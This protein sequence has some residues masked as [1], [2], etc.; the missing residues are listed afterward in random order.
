[1]AA[2]PSRN[3]SEL[4][5]ALVIPTAGNRTASLNNLI[6]D[7][8]VPG[9]LTYVVATKANVQCPPDVNCIHDLGPLNIHRWWNLG[10]DM[11]AVD[12]ADLVVVANDDALIDRT[13]VPALVTALCQT[14]ATLA[15]PGSTRR[16]YRR[17]LPLRWYLDGSFWVL[18]LREGIRADETYRWWM[19]DRDLEVRAR[20]QL[21]GLVTV[22]VVFD[23]TPG[24]QSEVRDDL[25]DLAWADMGLFGEQ[26]PVVTRAMKYFQ[27][28]PLW[29]QRC[30][31]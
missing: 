15:C 20:T 5:V 27:Q 17:G 28:L 3:P 22:P 8:G 2:K 6:R 7:S 31:P 29:L 4:R 9:R 18:D 24:T 13:T 23:H 30:W 26:H 1:M 10:L 16:V 12:G 11:A 25:M 21:N 19:G 14:G